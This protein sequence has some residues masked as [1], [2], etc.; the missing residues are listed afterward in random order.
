MIINKLIKDKKKTLIT[1][2]HVS[3][4][5][6]YNIEDTYILKI[7]DNIEQLKHE[8]EFNDLLIDKL[9]VCKSI[10]FEIKDNKAYYTL[11][12][13][14]KD[15]TIHAIDSTDVIWGLGSFHCLSQQEPALISE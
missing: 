7:S 3:G 12:E 1:N 5:E 6:V 11:E 10:A 15:Y 13:C 9:P 2:F 4:D 8:K 14:F